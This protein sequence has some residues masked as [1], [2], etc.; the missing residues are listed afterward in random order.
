MTN[1][2]HPLAE[3]WGREIKARRELFSLTRIQLA[4]HLGVTR[5]IVR[6]WEKGEHAPGPKMQSHIIQY[7]GIDP[8]TVAKLMRESYEATS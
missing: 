4:E 2:S 1:D 5:Q 6:L 8:V 3:A 7:L